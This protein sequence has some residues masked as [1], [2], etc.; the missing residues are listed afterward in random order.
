MTREEKLELIAKDQGWLPHPVTGLF[1]SLEARLAGM[2][3]ETGV[4]EHVP[5]YFGCLNACREM[6]TSLKAHGLIEY[7]SGVYHS[8]QTLYVCL[9]LKVE[10]WPVLGHTA[11]ALFELRHADAAQCAEAYGLARGLWT[12]KD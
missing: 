11:Q 7:N 2:R 8:E 5:D 1:Y 10:Q 6:E 9:V 12:E 4:I 3:A